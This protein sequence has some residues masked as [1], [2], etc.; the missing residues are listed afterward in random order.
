MHTN[1]EQTY[2]VSITLKT[3]NEGDL[4]ALMELREMADVVVDFGPSGSREASF[5]CPGNESQIHTIIDALRNDDNVFSFHF[6]PRADES[7][8][9]HDYH[10]RAHRTWKEAD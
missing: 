3:E 1:S 10:D 8:A 5:V 9:S 4:C 2:D 6:E 7:D